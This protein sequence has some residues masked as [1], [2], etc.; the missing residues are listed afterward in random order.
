MKNSFVLCV[1]IKIPSDIKDILGEIDEPIY[2]EAPKEIVQKK[3][4]QKKKLEKLYKKIAIFESKY[5]M[6]YSAFSVSVPDTQKGHG[7]WI[8]WSYLQKVSDEL[9]SNIKK[10]KLLLGK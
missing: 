8:E 4:A 3:L 10:L 2:V 1:S 5:G 7:D 9:A 6:G